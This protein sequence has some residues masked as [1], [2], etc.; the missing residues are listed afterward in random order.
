M[1][2]LLA[3]SSISKSF[4]GVSALR[5]LS[6]DDLPRARELLDDETFR[7]VRHVV[8]RRGGKATQAQTAADLSSP[9]IAIA[10]RGT[11]LSRFGVRPAR[12]WT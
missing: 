12:K 1:D 4:E 3:A 6:V 9:E 10:S 8:S 11:P 7:R 5:D 2:I